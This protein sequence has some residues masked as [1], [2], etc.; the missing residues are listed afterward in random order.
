MARITGYGGKAPGRYGYGDGLILQVSPKGASTWYVRMSIGGK[1]TMRSLGKA[2]A[3]LNSEA[4]RRLAA[5]RI[6]EAQEGMITLRSDQSGAKRV[7]RAT[8]GGA[9]TRWAG[10][11]LKGAHWTQQHHDKTL[12]RMELHLAPLWNVRLADLTRR[13][14]VDHLE[15]IE[16]VD[17]GGRMFSWLSE[18]LESEVDSGRL[19]H[20]VLGK[21][22]K[23]LV[24]SKKNKNRR[25]SYGKDYDKIAEL[26]RNIRLSDNSRSV[27]LAGMLSLLTGLRLGEIIELRLE[28]YRPDI[29]ALV[30]P[31]DKMKEKD[32][33][34]GDFTVP[35]SAPA[36]VCI[37][38]AIETQADGWLLPGPRSGKPVTHEGVEKVFRKLTDRRHVPHGTRTS[39]RTW[40]LERGA[41]MHVADSL[42]DH[43]TSKG[44]GEH[45][46]MTTFIDQRRELLESWA[47]VIA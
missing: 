33:W 36:L 7:S 32:P 17:T 2:S 1:S 31:R 22:P 6:A 19:Q 45:Y 42:I 4:A 27:R 29:Q 12:G 25:P 46:D 15:T 24:V 28:Y 10:S 21:K 3:M 37:E 8:V 9:L 38:E 40:A 26:Y 39:L 47:E 41:A 20:S 13:Q 18:A 30:I 34:R 11:Q 16:S 43:A 35:L 44:A 5:D 14:A 23:S